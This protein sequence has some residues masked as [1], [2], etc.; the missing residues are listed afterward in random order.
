MKHLKNHLTHLFSLALILLLLL[1]G[2]L[3]A[4]EAGTDNATYKVAAGLLKD[5]KFEEAWPKLAEAAKEEP[6]SL[7]ILS[8][9][10]YCAEKLN[11]PDHVKRI[12]AQMLEV[13]KTLENPTDAEKNRIAKAKAELAKGD[14]PSTKNS[15]GAPGKAESEPIVVE[16]DEDELDDPLETISRSNI[17][18]NTSY[19]VVIDKGA[20]LPANAK[21]S[22]DVRGVEIAIADGRIGND[23]L[24]VRDDN[25]DG[26]FTLDDTFAID[27]AFTFAPFAKYIG[28]TSGCYRVESMGEE[29]SITLIPVEVPGQIGIDFDGSKLEAHMAFTSTDTS[30]V[31]EGDGKYFDVPEGSFELQYG[32]VY[33]KKAKKPVAAVMKGGMAP[34]EIKAEKREKVK[35]G[36]DFRIVFTPVRKGDKIEISPTSLKVYGRA[37]EEYVAFEIQGKPSVWLMDG[38]KEYPMGR[39]AFG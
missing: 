9:C 28:T 36:E 39:F 7:A 10:A 6:K 38:K 16:L 25:N 12:Y 11:K 31:C 23:K 1:T 2:T 34:I 17:R 4:G 18:N 20:V 27:K 30:F 22:K 19:P 29:L 26:K 37:D 32:L 3:N 8:A 33:S 24:V 15:G 14:Q 13:G 35:M 21:S 5:G